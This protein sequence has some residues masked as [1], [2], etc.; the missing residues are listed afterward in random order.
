[1]KIAVFSDIHANLTALE[2]V[3]SH[4]NNNYKDISYIHLGDCIDYGMRPN[5]TIS[6][7]ISI[8]DRII[9]NIKGNHEMALYG[10][11]KDRFSSQRGADA[12]T[13]TKSILNKNSTDFINKM[14]DN[15]VEFEIDNKLFLCIHGDLS[16][17]YWGKMNDEELRQEKYQK[18]D[19][20]LSGHTHI[21][22][23]RDVINKEKKQK[24]LFVNPG[25]IGQP[26]NLNPNTQYCVI[27]TTTSSIHFHSLKYDIKTE[28]N[29]YK[30]EI[31]LY[32]RDRLYQGI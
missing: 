14:S 22:S 16:D 9:A 10:F 3:L 1:M 17:I 21:P 11:E 27:D 26:R 31:D 5:E 4:C 28:T 6:K 15:F 23:L 2:T 18:Y 13:Y 30:D 8:Q 19:Y 24:T 12:N 29:L 7:L 32:Y 25:S 20:V